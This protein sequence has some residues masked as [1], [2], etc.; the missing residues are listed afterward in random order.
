MSQ[1]VPLD[2]SRVAQDFQLRRTQVEC[3][4]ALLDEGNT[5]PFVA[6]FRRGRTGGLDEEIL[7]RLQARLARLRVLSDRKSTVLR[8]IDAQGRLTDELRAAI[9]AAES[10]KRLEDLYLPFKPKKPTAATEARERGLAGLAQVVWADAESAR[11][12][13]AACAAAIDPTKGLHTADDVL[14]GV[15]HIIAENISEIAVAR[16]AVRR[17]VWTTGKLITARLDNLP[18]EKGKSW[19]EYFQF[20]EALEKIAPQRVLAIDRGE[21]DHVLSVRVEFDRPAAQAAVHAVLPAEHSHAERLRVWADEALARVIAPSLDREV[22][23]ELGEEAEEHAA[24]LLGRTLRCLLL[25]P[26]LR[27]VRL[28]AIDPGFRTGCKVAALDESGKLLAHAVIHPH[29]PQG[30]RAEAKQTLV[31]LAREHAAA[32]VAIGN[33]PGCRETEE[34]VAESIAESLGELNYTIVNEVGASAYATSAIGREE[35]SNIDANTRTAVSIGRRAQDPLAELVKI[36]AQQFAAGMNQHDLHGRVLKEF[37]GAAVESCVNQVG[38]DLNTAGVPLLRFVSGLNQLTAR[39]IVERRA[40][41]GPFTRRDEIKEVEGITDAVFAQAAGFLHIRDGAN[42]LD[43]TSVH[44]ENYEAAEKLLAKLGL[45]CD[46]LKTGE[47]VAEIRAKLASADIETLGKELEIAPDL[48]SDLIDGLR[49]PHRD[50]R[51]GHAPA[52]MRR[53]L[54][55]LE[56]LKQG[57]ELQGRVLNVVDF[58][59]FVDIG[60]KESGLV[61]ISQVSTRFIRSPQDVATVGQITTVWVLGVDNERSRVSLTMIRPGTPRREATVPARPA[62]STPAP[63]PPHAPTRAE[64]RPAASPAAAPRTPARPAAARP[65]AT[66]PRKPRPVPSLPKD[67]L[68]GAA[69][70]RS[71]GELK[72]LWEARKK[73]E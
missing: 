6:R 16:E 60:L 29:P 30:Q 36:D 63:R 24:R 70:A 46:S 32:L 53:S 14:A 61:H 10:V 9:E 66:P 68:Q 4:V 42:P 15:G 35:L 5:I 50:P 39:R 38:V 47:G 67:V 22:R 41:K 28:L 18:D 65:A 49:N 54:V 45:S 55:K 64:P 51:A 3:V 71:F 8:S 43:A 19:R 7:R 11:D 34:L 1:P 44:P 13:A 62:A 26:P 73:G 52:I 40:A 58:G 17:I 72:L 69:P 25:Q 48:M 27:G 12:L 23:R 2:L 21:K 56:D 33:G 57:Q 31:N 37:L 20:Q 59:V